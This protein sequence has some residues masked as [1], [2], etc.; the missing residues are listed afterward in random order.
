M[1][2]FR[3]AGRLADGWLASSVTPTEVAA[4]IEAIRG[5]ARAGGR[6]IPEDHFGVLIPYCLAADRRQALEIAGPGVRRRED[7]AVT[8][9]AALGKPEEV[10]QKLRDFIAAGASK[11]VMRPTG[12]RESLRFQVEWLAAEVIPALQTPFSADE[13]AKRSALR[14]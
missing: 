12:P 4:G 3:R 10:R 14:V 1:A 13:R 7:V 8:E 9:F 6:E 2:A 5:H 11:F